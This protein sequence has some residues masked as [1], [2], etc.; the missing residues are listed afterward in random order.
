MA[1]YERIVTTAAGLELLENAAFLGGSIQFTA[2]KTG[3]GTYDGTEELSSMTD[4]KNVCQT[5]GIGSVSKNEGNVIV[6]IVIDNKDLTEG[7]TMTELGLYAINPDTGEELLYAIILAETGYEDYVPPYADAP[8]SITFE[9]YFELTE[10]TEPVT[11]TAAYME[12]VYAP[13]E[14]FNEH[15]QNNEIHVTKEEKENWNSKQAALTIDTALDAD[16]ENPVQNKAIA[17]EINKK[18]NTNGGNAS[19]T[20]A[21]FTEATELA[22]LTTGSKLSVLFGLIAKAVSSLISHIKDTAIHFTAAERTKLSGIA[23]GANAYTH[24]NSGATAGTYRSVT[25]NEQGHV[26]GGTN[27]VV[28]VAQGGTGATTAAAA[29]TNLGVAY[30]TAAGTVCQGNDSRLSDT[31]TPK[32]HNQAASTI[33]AGTLAGQV[34]AN[35]TAMDTL[36]TAQVRDAC[37][38]DADPGEGTASSLPAGT[39]VFSKE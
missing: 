29:R 30:G 18:L 38:V 33:T 26:T 25:V 15:V 36:A 20:T 37:I 13:A 4:L 23:A 2:L 32:A 31:R 6:R 39:L 8:A 12:G 19:N 22:A 27:P 24:P 11:F 14:S 16:S 17:T 9:A 35:T 7:Y 21:A 5:F 28:T 1:K 3:S 10:S 34:N